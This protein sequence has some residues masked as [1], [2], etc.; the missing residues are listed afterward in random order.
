MDLLE[1]MKFQSRMFF[2]L[3]L[4]FPWPI[5][6]RSCEKQK[7]CIYIYIYIYYTY[8]NTLLINSNKRWVRH[9][10]I[11]RMT[12]R[13]DDIARNAIYFD[14]TID[15]MTRRKKRGYAGERMEGKGVENWN[16]RLQSKCPLTQERRTQYQLFCF[17]VNFDILYIYIYII[18]KT[19]L[20]I[21]Y[22]WQE[23]RNYI[24]IS[25]P[26]TVH[27]ARIRCTAKKSKASPLDQSSPLIFAVSRRVRRDTHV[28]C[29]HRIC[30]CW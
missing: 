20:Y 2:F 28:Y 4:N 15:R 10:T 24:I 21:Y 23:C 22:F 26:W 25:R 14:T 27:R 18:Y 6:P 30:E 7:V 8:I 1:I 3:L 5:N 11:S 16:Y 12:L 19:T 13:Q 29:S 17:F 9:A